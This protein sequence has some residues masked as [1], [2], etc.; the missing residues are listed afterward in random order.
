M[1][2]SAGRRRPQPPASLNAQT[3]RRSAP[4]TTRQV[5]GEYSQH[6]RAQT[7]TPKRDAAETADRPKTS[8]RA[9]S[10]PNRVRHDGKDQKFRPNRPVAEELRSGRQIRPTTPPSRRQHLPK[11]Q[12]KGLN[13]PSSRHHSASRGIKFANQR[14]THRDQ[15]CA[16]QGRSPRPAARPAQPTPACAE[17][18]ETDGQV[19]KASATSHTIRHRL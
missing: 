11:R 10:A 4:S 8:K 18:P 6:S 15:A 1:P 19:R 12:P 14:G 2:R 17:A 5:N 13:I 7:L 9:R 3:R 16:R